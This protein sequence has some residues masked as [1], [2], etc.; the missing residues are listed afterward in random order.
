MWFPG[1]GHLGGQSGLS[2]VSL[3]PSGRPAVQKPSR[4]RS[5]RRPGRALGLDE[6]VT[7]HPPC[8]RNIPPDAET[9]GSA[10]GA[11]P[12]VRL[13]PQRRH[14]PG[15]GQYREGDLFVVA[16]HDVIRSTAQ[17]HR[18]RRSRRTPVL[19]PGRYRNRCA[20]CAASV[21]CR[22]RVRR[23]VGATS[24]SRHP[25]VRI[26]QSGRPGAGAISARDT[27]CSAAGTC[28]CL[29]VAGAMVGT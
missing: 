1:S 29:S 10:A 22:C 20:W 16:D 2:V 6:T 17:Q 11:V 4:H 19:A 15:I 3:R 13:H 7:K 24:D 9:R 12:P 5:R 14:Q 28:R 18:R 21:W 25:T 27:T 26:R 8:G 23:T